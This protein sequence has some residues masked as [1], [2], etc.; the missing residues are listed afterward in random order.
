MVTVGTDS[1]GDESGLTSFALL[2]GITISLPTGSTQTLDEYK[3]TLLI[4]SMDYLEVQN[5]LGVK[6]V[7]TQALQFPRAGIVI[8]GYTIDSATVPTDIVKAQYVGALLIS[9]GYELQSPLTQTIKRRKVGPLETEYQDYS[10][11]AETFRSLDSV[12][13]PYIQSGVKIIRT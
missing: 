12:L 1:Y 3:T 5:Y 13:Y 8:D 9:Q 7:S 4:K 2:R 6:T 10:T 11:P